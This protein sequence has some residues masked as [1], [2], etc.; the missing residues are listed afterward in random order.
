MTVNSTNTRDR[1][2]SN[3]ADFT[4]PVFGTDD[5]KVSIEAPDGSVTV[6]GVAQYTVTFRD[7]FDSRSPGTVTLT[8]PADWLD[9]ND[10]L[11]ADYTV[12]IERDVQLTQPTPFNQL[13]T[14]NPRSL[15]NALDRLTFQIQDLKRQAGLEND[16]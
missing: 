15:E 8:G 11:V 14:F 2:Q 7:E 5:L 16:P 9:N 3:P 13:A 12:I 1:V 6:L 4:F 10:D